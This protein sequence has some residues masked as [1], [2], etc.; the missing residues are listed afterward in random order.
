MAFSH[1]RLVVYRV[2]IEF[3]AWSQ[4]IVDVLPPGISARGQLERASTSVP[5]NIAEGNM[6]SS[7]RDRCR[8]WE[9]ACGSAVECAA[10]LDVVVA[11]GMRS[12]EQVEEGKVLLERITSLLIRLIEVTR[13]GGG[14]DNDNDDDNEPEG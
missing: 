4:T 12:V 3:V 14:N 5:L 9:I 6:K 10:V 1:D 8:Y 11:R 13:N 7:K 2:A